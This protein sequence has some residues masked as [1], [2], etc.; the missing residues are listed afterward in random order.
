MDCYG[1]KSASTGESVNSELTIDSQM[2]PSQNFKSDAK[3]ICKKCYNYFRQ[4]NISDAAAKGIL[5][6]IYA[7]SGFQ[8]NI[9]TWDGSIKKD[10]S[11]KI[12]SS[13]FG[14]GGGLI[15]FYYYGALVGLAKYIDGNTN[16]IDTLNNRIKNSGLPKPL[17]P[18]SATST[19]YIRN[20]GFSFP[21]TLEQ[22]LKYITNSL[23]V[24]EFKTMTNPSEAARWWI[25]KVERPAMKSN[26]WAMFGKTII[27]MLS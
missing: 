2:S 21:Y 20:K 15:G 14:I 5:V 12:V 22:Q 8:Y 3:D 19:K 25:E 23:V 6:N 4:K 24:S 27:K 18:L 9:L 11:G 17:T 16:R 13:R 26:R 10:K 1:N 7:E